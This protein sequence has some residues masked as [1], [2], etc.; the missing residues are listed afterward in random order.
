MVN[1]FVT[2]NTSFFK[3]CPMKEERQA[4]QTNTYRL[5][6]SQYL[7]LFVCQL[8]LHSDLA[9]FI[10]SAKHSRQQE[11]M[12]VKDSSFKT[13]WKVECFDPQDRLESKGCPVMVR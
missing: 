3:L 5:I 8:Y 9:T 2:I 7:Q 10:K 13:A 4:T 6:S 11:V 1:V 12:L